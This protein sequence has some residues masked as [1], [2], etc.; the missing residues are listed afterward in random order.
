MAGFQTK[1]FT[2]H[3]DYMTP[4]SAWENVKHIIPQDKVIWE[5]FYGDGT[6]GTI[7]KDMGFNTIHEPIDFFENDKGEIVVSN[8]PFTKIPEILTRLKYLNKPFMLIMPSSKLQTQYFRKLFSNVEEPIQIIIP[9]KRIQFIR[10]DSEGNPETDKKN[11]KCNFDCFY[12]C[13]K[14]NLEKDIIWLE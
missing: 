13:Y 8:P 6:S 11:M 1:T 10:I 12:Y 7:L 5:A 9:R 14:M 3:D 4:K 2:K